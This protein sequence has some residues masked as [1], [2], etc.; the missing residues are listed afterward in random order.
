M[1]GYKHTYIQIYYTDIYIDTYRNMI[2]ITA[3]HF[4]DQI[5]IVRNS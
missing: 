1:E 3:R 4:S 5:K 2:A